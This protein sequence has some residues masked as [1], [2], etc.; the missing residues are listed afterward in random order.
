MSELNKAKAVTFILTEDLPAS[1]LYYQGKLGLNFVANDGFADV[2]NLGNT[3]LRI[4]EIPGVVASAHPALGWDVPDIVKAAKELISSGIEMT[5]YDGFGQD[6]LGSWTA[7]DGIA[8]VAW[9]KD[10]DGNVLSM[11]Q[12]ATSA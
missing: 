4:T 11:T 5:I 3:L 12:I 2:Y 6:D 1:K 10:G 8:K 7:P 9:F